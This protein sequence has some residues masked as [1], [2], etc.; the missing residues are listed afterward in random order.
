MGAL[1]R[2]YVHNDIDFTGSARRVLAIAESMVGD[3]AHGRDRA[4]GA[5]AAS[6][7]QRAATA[8]TSRTTTTSPTRSTGCGSTR[9]WSIRARISARGDDSLD[10]AQAQKLDHI[11]RKLRLA[12]GERFLDIGCGWG[13]LIFWAARALRRRRRPASRCRR[14]STTTCTAQIAARGLAGRVQRASCGTTLDLPED[15]AVRQ[16]RERGH[17]R[18]RRARATSDRYFGKIRR[19]LEPGRLRAEPRHHAQR[20]R[21]SSSLGSGIGEFVEEYVFPGGELAHVSRVD[22]GHG[23]AGPRGRST[24]RRC[25]ST[26]RGR[27]GTGST[28]SSRTPTR[29]AREV[30]EEKIPRLAHLHG[31][32]G[33]RVRSRLDVAVAAAG[34][35]AACRR[36]PA[37]SADARLHVREPSAAPVAAAYRARVASAAAATAYWRIV[38]GTPDLRPEHAMNMTAPAPVAAQVSALEFPCAFPIKIMGRTQ[39]GFAQAIADIVVP[40]RAGFRSAPTL[41]MRTSSAGN[42]LS[43]TATVNATSREQLDDL[44]RELVAQPMVAMVLLI[45]H[46]RAHGRRRLPVV[47]TWADRLRA[48]WRAMQAFTDARTPRHARRDLADRASA[49]LH[50]GPRRPARAP[51]ARQRHSGLKVDR[52]GQVTYHGP[53]QLVAYLLFDLRRAALGV[54]E[55]VRRIEAAVIDMARD[56]YGIAAYGK[57]RRAGRLRRGATAAKRRSRAL[58]LKVRNGC[59]YHGLAVNV[60][61]D[62]APF[63]DIDPCGYP[64]LAVTQLADFGVARTV[65]AAGDELAPR[66]RWRAIAHGRMTDDRAPP[67]IAAPRQRRRRQAQGRRQDVRASRSR[68]SPAERAAQAGLDPRARAVVAALLRDQADPARAPAAHGVRGS[69]VPE[70]RRV[71]RQGHGDVHDHGRHLH[72]PLPVLRRRPRPAAAARR[73]RAASISRETIAALGLRYVVIT[74]VDRDDLRDGGAQHFVDCIR[75]VREHSPATQI[76]VL[77]PDFRGRLDRALDDPDAGAARRDE[78]QPRDG[79]AALP[80]GAAGLRLRAFAAPAAGVQGAL[81]ATC[82]PSRGLMVGLG[83]TD[84]EILAGDARHAR[85]RHRHA[86][87]RP[88]PAAV[89]APPAGAALRASRTRSRCSSARRTRWASATPPSARMVR[90]SYHADRQAEDVLGRLRRIGRCVRRTRRSAASRQRRPSATAA[91]SGPA[92]ASVPPARR[93]RRRSPRRNRRAPRPRIAPPVSCAITSRCSGAS[94]SGC[95]RGEEDRRAERNRSAGR[96]RS[97]A[98]ASSGTPSVPIGPSIAASSVPARGGGTSRKNT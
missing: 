34:R 43:L 26:T 19:L 47:R 81:P 85:A 30:G 49:G 79:A 24:A 12:P 53:G 10:D 39:D 1:A 82:R 7:H 58:G 73:R 40:A 13:A 65:D 46:A 93:H 15:E 57:R 33:A 52:G 29:R 96:R 4:R 87:D 95:G 77:V 38:A 2:A 41:E 74:S 25:A 48:T 66:A 98:R 88:V 63:A 28:G 18:A 94:D 60:D 9:G 97:C 86:D 64:G 42:Y 72:A 59:T 11:C 55:L 54:R 5:A 84:D 89:G 3:I 21:R 51:A 17:V 70:H 44:Y 6:L 67:A 32:L 36:P 61:M 56:R 27:C 62:L 76:E 90:S 92:A 80:A 31:G 23:R 50:A 22:R 14:T 71:L 16:D 35:Q 75:A 20:A 78:P 37:A 91:T 68:S 8:R 83:E 69:V 45:A